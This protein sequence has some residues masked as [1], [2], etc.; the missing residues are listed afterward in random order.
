MSTPFTLSILITVLPELS[1][2]HYYATDGRCCFPNFVRNYDLTKFDVYNAFDRK[3]TEHQLRRVLESDPE[4]I[5]ALS[6]L[7]RSENQLDNSENSKVVENTL[8]YARI[9]HSRCCWRM[10]AK[11]KLELSRHEIQQIYRL[12]ESRCPTNQNYTNIAIIKILSDLAPVS[13]YE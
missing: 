3:F 9:F 2:G 11:R 6:E 12:I 4:A 13:V 7:C 10:L 1:S 5:D 8:K